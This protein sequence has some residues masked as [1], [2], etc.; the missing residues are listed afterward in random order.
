M[1]TRFFDVSSHAWD[2]NYRW[3]QPPQ[4]AYL[5]TTCDIRGNVNSTPVTLG[6]L[7]GATEPRYGRE[8][9][10]YFTFSLGRVHRPDSGNEIGVRHGYLNLRHS[11]ECVISYLTDDLLDAS[12]IAGLPVPRGISEIDVAGLTPLASTMVNPPGIAECAVNMEARIETSYPLGSYYQLYIA[13]VV[14]ASVD[15]QAIAADT[16]LGIGGVDPIFEVAIESNPPQSGNVRMIY[17]HLDATRITRSRDDIGC[18]GD[19]IGSFRKW[20]ESEV[21]RGRLDRGR[22]DE[23]LALEIA[24]R[25]DPDPETNGTVKKRLTEAL[26]F[27]CR[28]EAGSGCGDG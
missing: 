2:I 18:V 9:E 7:V 15:T 5:V 1:G 27:L 25:K 14:G 11:D 23:M 19:W 10:C 26:R 12:T 13:R 3:L 4:I 21:S 24:W 17:G 16:G 28:G 20:I 22:A 8:A 6:T